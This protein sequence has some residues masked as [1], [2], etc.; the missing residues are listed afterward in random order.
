MLYLKRM[1]SE[2]ELFESIVVGEAEERVY[3]LLGLPSEV[4]DTQEYKDLRYWIVFDDQDSYSLLGTSIGLP[5]IIRIKDGFV[6]SKGRNED[7]YDP[8]QPGWVP[9]NQGANK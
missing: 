1:P 8:Y 4:N 9:I 3:E 5:R 7:Y 6:I 2:G